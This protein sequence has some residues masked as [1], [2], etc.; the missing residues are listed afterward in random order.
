MH[1]IKK[2]NGKLFANDQDAINGS[3]KNK[4]YT[5]SPKYNFYNIFHQYPYRFLAKLCDFD[6]ISYDVFQEAKKNPIII[7]YLGEERPWRVGN[8]HKYKDDYLKYLNMTPWKNQN[9]EN[10]WK[11][12]FICW[13]IFNFII[14]PFP[15]LRYK[16][17][18]S[19]IPVF[20]K[21]RSRKLIKNKEK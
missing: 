15:M 8:K 5:L 14:K 12:Y 13:N 3:Q 4:I 10:G 21:I 19:L 17:I 20:I 16:I 11:L 6:Y 2:N 18:N 1:F 9:I 7:H